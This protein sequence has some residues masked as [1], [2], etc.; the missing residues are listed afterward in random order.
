LGR[1]ST[2]DGPHADSIVER[3]I[4]RK[5][6]KR[7]VGRPIGPDVY[8]L[9]VRKGL[10]N[11]LVRDLHTKK[12]KHLV[13]NQTDE[14]GRSL[15]HI[16]TALGSGVGNALIRRLSE[17]QKFVRG[18][19]ERSVSRGQLRTALRGELK[20][21]GDVSCLRTVGNATDS[22]RI[23]VGLGNRRGVVFEND[24]GRSMPGYVRW[25]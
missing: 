6:G 3:A 4:G 20:L 15:L 5:V 16:G 18:I 10:I 24:L 13:R 2:V 8:V 12:A 17:G 19:D 9:L 1:Q 22:D 14:T 21:N 11:V 7:S 23:Y 25:R